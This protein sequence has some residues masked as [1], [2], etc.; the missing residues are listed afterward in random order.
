QRRGRHSSLPLPAPLPRPPA[1]SVCSPLPSPSVTSQPP[2][3]HRAS[4]VSASAS[5]VVIE[6]APLQSLPCSCRSS[7]LSRRWPAL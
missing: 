2:W 3:L 1:A 4:P 6:L 7:A 5:S